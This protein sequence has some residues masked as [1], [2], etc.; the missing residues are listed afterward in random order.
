MAEDGVLRYP[1]IAVNDATG[2]VRSGQ[3]GVPEG[4]DHWIL[5]FDGVR[6]SQ[7]GEPA[8]Y[9]RIEFAYHQMATAG[10][11]EMTP[12]RLLEES[13]RAHFM[14]RRFDRLAGNRKRGLDRDEEREQDEGQDLHGHRYGVISIVRRAGRCAR[15]RSP[16]NP[17][18]RRR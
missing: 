11:I 6:D 2:E 13:D 17:G 9:G 7:L 4:F 3:V 14:T 5:K 16:W 8:G 12:C 1:I 10:G 18:D 15:V